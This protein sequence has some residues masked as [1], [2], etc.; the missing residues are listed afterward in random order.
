MTSLDRRAVLAAG[1]G[2]VAGTAAAQATPGG[3]EDALCVRYMDAWKRKDLTTIAACLHPE[4]HFLGPM[5]ETQSKQAFLDST[6]R[7]L[8]ALVRFEPR[9][10]F[11]AR[12]RAM[13]AY[14]FVAR[15]P[16]GL[17]RTAELVMLRDGLIAR[18]ELFY[19]ARPFEAA[20]RAAS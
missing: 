7:I 2:L 6:A 1:G 14:D 11:V 10:T 3:G 15:D 18:I 17:C 9:A 19:D 4:L 16:I 8:P 5:L 20:R 13:F 12:D